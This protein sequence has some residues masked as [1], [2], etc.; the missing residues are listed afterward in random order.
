LGDSSSAGIGDGKDIYPFQL[1]ESLQRWGGVRV[2]NWASPGLSS[3]DACKFYIHQIAE[4]SVDFLVIYLGNNE[5]SRSRYKGTY[6]PVRE[7]IGELL[8]RSAH[9]RKPFVLGKRRPYVFDPAPVSSEIATTPTDFYRNLRTIISRAQRAG[10]QVV[11]VNPV[12]NS[13]FP[14]GLGSRN[15]PFYRYVG[16]HDT[17]GPEL[18]ADADTEALVQGIRWHARNKLS[19]ASDCY[20]LVKPDPPYCYQVARNNLAVAQYESGERSAAVRTLSEA[21]DGEYYDR[22]IPLYNLGRIKNSTRILKEAYEVDST[23]YRVKGAYRE[24]VTRLATVLGV[25]VLDMAGIVTDDHF[26]DYCHLTREGHGILAEAIHAVVTRRFENLRGSGS[27]VYRCEFPSPDYF[28]RSG[29]DLDDYYAITA[30]WSEEEISHAFE[31]A[32]AA[33]SGEVGEIVEPNTTSLQNAIQRTVRRALDHPVVTGIDD[34]VSFPVRYSHEIGSFPE[35]YLYRLLRA[36]GLVLDKSGHRAEWQEW[37][38]SFPVRGPD[39]Y[40]RLILA[41]RSDG[42]GKDEPDLSPGRRDRVLDRVEEVLCRPELYASHSSER[43]KTIMYWYTRESFRFGTQSRPSMLYDRVGLEELA[44]S[45]AV[46]WTIERLQGRSGTRE[47][48]DRC[49]RRIEAL[50]GVHEH[51]ASRLASD[52]SELTQE[53]Y[54]A[55]LRQLHVGRDP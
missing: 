34:A 55:A 13:Y 40:D 5:G 47:R 12:A 39:D 15:S 52:D 45:V 22:A 9:T 29:E 26:V 32:C 49:R 7:R 42:F 54:N 17:I 31:G 53:A 37:C 6:R 19:E 2:D 46:A 28:F 36:Y 21:L 10:T 4:R 8:G 24:A 1:F 23:L 33:M 27:S 50:I 18:V 14:A 44:E 25:H 3:A 51:F 38:G 41:R 48:V 16:F 43:R 35:F 20:L 11:L 30:G